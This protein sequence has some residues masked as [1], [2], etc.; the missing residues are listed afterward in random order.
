M[1][2]KTVT[3][4][5]FMVFLTIDNVKHEI[6][7]NIVWVSNKLIKKQKRVCRV[8]QILRFLRLRHRNYYPKT[9]FKQI[10]LVGAKMRGNNA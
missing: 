1:P 2:P 8:C 3:N 7:P 6:K 5:R 9:K 4:G 10:L